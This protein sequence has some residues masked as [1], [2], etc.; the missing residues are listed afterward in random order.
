MFRVATICILAYSKLLK[1][2]SALAVTDSK[3]VAA[4]NSAIKQAKQHR[5]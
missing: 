2:L 3:Q 4:L 1:L 5:V